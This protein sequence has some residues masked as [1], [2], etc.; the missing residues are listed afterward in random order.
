MSARPGPTALALLFLFGSVP[1]YPQDSTGPIQ[2][3]VASPARVPSPAARAPRTSAACPVLLQLDTS[4]MLSAAQLQTFQDQLRRIWEPYDVELTWTQRASDRSLPGV[5]LHVVIDQP[6]VPG[7]ADTTTKTALGS[8]TFQQTGLAQDVLYASASGLWRALQQTR[9]RGQPVAGLP[10]V[11]Q[12]QIVAQALAR[13]I[14]HELGHVLLASSGHA[15]RG[16]MR[17]VFAPDDLVS[18]LSSFRL[19]PSERDQLTGVGHCRAVLPTR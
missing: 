9:Y 16:L 17:P 8:T 12:E 11:L 19:E 5:Y 7:T 14:A 4:G 6:A 13:V 10:R 18:G 2:P 15:A 3:S 1:A